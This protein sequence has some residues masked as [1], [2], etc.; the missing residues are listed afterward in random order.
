MNKIVIA[1]LESWVKP[2]TV[3]NNDHKPIW[4]P[5]VVGVSS[6][7]DM[8]GMTDTRVTTSDIE[9]RNINITK[10]R[11]CSF[12]EKDKYLKVTRIACLVESCVLEF[13]ANRRRGEI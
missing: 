11:I 5:P 13:I 9:A 12:L 7:I 6:S 8:K 1:D 4:V 10:K 3:G 2:N